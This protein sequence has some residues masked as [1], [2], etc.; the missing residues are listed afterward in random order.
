MR[1]WSQVQTVPRQVTLE[2]R[3]TCSC[4]A[5]HRNGLSTAALY[6]AVPQAWTSPSQR[7]EAEAEWNY[8]AA[9]PDE[10]L[11]LTG[12]RCPALRHHIYRRLR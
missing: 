2:D 8:Y 7:V 3:D 5:F 10:S 4:S 6:S 12:E 1:Q 9:D 11:G